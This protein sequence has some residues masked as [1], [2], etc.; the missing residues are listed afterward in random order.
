MLYI[1]YIIYMY[2]AG[3][4]MYMYEDGWMDGWINRFSYR[5]RHIGS[6]HH[7][8]LYHLQ[9]ATLPIVNTYSI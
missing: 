4:T 8:L 2:K 1:I 5:H 9:L 7:N 6:V 3:P